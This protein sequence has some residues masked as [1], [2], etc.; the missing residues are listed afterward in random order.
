MMALITSHQHA[1]L[2]QR[3]RA[4]DG[5]G[6]AAAGWDQITAS[7]LLPLAWFST[8]FRVVFRRLSPVCPPPLALRFSPPF[9]CASTAFRLRFHRLPVRRLCLSPLGPADVQRPCV[10]FSPPLACA[11]F[12]RAAGG[13]GGR[14]SN[15]DGADQAGRRA[16]A[17]RR[18]RRR[19]DL[20]G[21][22]KRPTICHESR[23]FLLIH[24]L[25]SSSTYGI[26]LGLSASS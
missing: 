16:L 24:T 20:P 11:P 13:G 4:G 22:K 15:S 2:R 19:R 25:R 12:A 21:S 17:A 10:L 26:S 3:G 6:D 14:Q 5:R 18:R 9:A 1:R 7:R 8:A 23:T